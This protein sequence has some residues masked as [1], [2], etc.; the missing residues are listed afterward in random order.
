MKFFLIF[1][2]IIEGLSAIA[3]LIDIM[4]CVYPR[5][6]QVYPWED[7]LSFLCAVGLIIWVALLL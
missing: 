6:R 7:A 2:L 1:L 3:H 4:T 5:M